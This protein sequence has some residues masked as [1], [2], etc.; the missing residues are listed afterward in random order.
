MLL[1]LLLIFIV[2][3]LALPDLCSSR[4]APVLNKRGITCDLK[5]GIAGM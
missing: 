2:V 4:N 5:I 1:L 3:I